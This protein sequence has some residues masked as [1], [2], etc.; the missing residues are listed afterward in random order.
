M[1]T[2]QSFAAEVQRLDRAL[3]ALTPLAAAAGVAPPAGQEW[4]DLLRNKLLAQLD[5]P[6]LLVVA[7]VGGTNIGKSVIFN[8]LAGEV[9]SASSPLAAGTKNPVCLVPPDLA[10]A[11][12][13]GRLFEPFA[14]HAWASADDPLGDSP[15]NRLFWR[16]GKTMP[17]RLLLLDAPDV[18][19]DVA[20]NWRRA[21]AIRQAA[22]VLVAVL[23]QQKYNDAAVKQF[24]R[25]AVEADKPIIV[26]F[27]QCELE[28][29]REYWPQW[30]DT[31]C[32]QTG[33]RPELVY[34]V[35]YDRRAAEELRL[36]FYNISALTL[37][38]GR[39]ARA[40]MQNAMVPMANG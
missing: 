37:G 25:A 4:F 11:A 9:A 33:A 10:D 21:T 20:V 14:L 26:V 38:E 31:F 24:F 18:D 22:D 7:I 16:V 30:L 12:L 8:L 40:E 2:Y 6:P 32:Q 19:S 1:P 5:L 13:L 15:E 17:P 35:P 27:N 29:D 28:A 3:G 34:V 36:P 39:G 23:T